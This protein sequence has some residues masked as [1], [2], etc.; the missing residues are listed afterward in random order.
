MA[1]S[2]TARVEL[3]KKAYTETLTPLLDLLAL[4]K[5][6]GKKAGFPDP[7]GS[8]SDEDEESDEADDSDEDEDEESDDE[9]SDDE[10]SDE[11]D[12][13]T[14][15]DEEDEESDEDEDEEEESLSPGNLKKVKAALQSVL[16]TTGRKDAV[17]LLTKFKVEKVSDL[18]KDQVPL[19]TKAAEK[20]VATAPR[21]KVKSKIKK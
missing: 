4:L 21:T 6:A 5:A 1:R 9:E 7:K 16:D 17:S 8:A 14:D 15:E 13:E 11:S 2:P 19:F 10:E 3:S 20:L 18:N 12:D